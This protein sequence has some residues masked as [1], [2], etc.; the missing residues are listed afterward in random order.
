MSKIID[1]NFLKLE[2]RELY[3]KMKRLESEKDFEEQSKIY[4]EIIVEVILMIFDANKQEYDEDQELEGNIDRLVGSNYI[5]SDLAKNINEILD[6]IDLCSSGFIA[7]CDIQ[8]VADSNFLKIYEVIVWLVINYGEEDYSLFLNGLKCKEKSIF[9]KHLEKET[10]LIDDYLVKAG[11]DYD[12]TEVGAYEVAVGERYYKGIDGKREYREARS[13]FEKA[14]QLGNQLGE[15]YLALFYEKGLGGEKDLDEAIFWY[16]KAALKG[17]GFAQYS[18]GFIYYNGKGVER[19]LKFAFQWYKKAA[20]NNFPA[21]QYVIAYFYK[22]GEGCDENLFK[23]YYW[24]DKAAKNNYDDAFYSLGELYYK[25]A[26]IDVNYKKAFTFFQKGADLGEKRCLE[27]LGDLYYYGLHVDEDKAKAFEYYDKSIQKGNL[28]FYKV[29]KLYESQLDMEKAIEYYT[30]GHK[31]G[32]IKSTQKLGVLYY[33]GIGVKKDVTKALY[34]I[35]IAADKDE[36]HAL[37]VKGSSLLL[38]NRN[39]AMDYLKKAYFGGSYYAAETLAGELLKDVFKGKKVN[40]NELITYIDTGVKNGLN[41]CVY[42]QGLVYSN[43]IGVI[44]NNEEAYVYFK[45]AAQKG[46]KKAILKLASWYKHG[47]FVKPNIREAI[48]WYKKAALDLNQE[49]L[50][51][52]IDI[53]HNG[54][55]VKRDDKKAY[56]WA[57]L[58]Q[59]TNTIEGNLIIAKFKING[60]GIEEN[61][62]EGLDIVEKSKEINIG[63]V[64]RFLGE[65]AEEEAVGFKKEEVKNVYKDAIEK[66]CNEAYADLIYYA[67]KNGDIEECNELL[68]EI[69]REDIIIESGKLLYVKGMQKL[70]RAEENNKQDEVNKAIKEIKKSIHLGFYEGVKDIIEYYKNAEKTSENLIEY[71]KYKQK[72]EYYSLKELE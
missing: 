37:Y 19:N 25:G 7:D 34:Y 3:N 4:I 31:M 53:F 38:E 44:K 54:I 15:A 51:N 30:R 66:G 23:T 43:G 36:T 24:L 67:Y 16:K 41:E 14:A 61:V 6:D 65:L 58:L 48:R 29:G 10:I 63:R 22:Q 64:F 72:E 60:Y 68:N 26:Y 42:Y 20:E 1:Y 52:L 5:T 70:K 33:N 69:D 12:Q 2:Y 9:I 27:G 32:D 40:E 39:K 46:S 50:L 8:E 55:G 56:Q 49:A 59:K 71:Y 28:I 11:I 17:N 47:I 35:D 21:A 18:L 45:N 13:Y 62:K 57:E